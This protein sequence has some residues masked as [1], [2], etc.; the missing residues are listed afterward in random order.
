MKRI[1]LATSWRNEEQPQLVQTLRAWHHKVYDFRNPPSGSGGFAWNQLDP[2]WEKWSTTVY[3][4]KLLTDPVAAQGFM[5]DLRGMQW[6]DTFV[7]LQPCGRSAHL[8]LG[9][10][11]GRGKH[12]IIMLRKGE[13]ELMVLLADELVTNY[14]EL[15]SALGRE[16]YLQE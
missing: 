10:G 8:E 1:Y 5:A 12:T 7:L 14:G 13:P 2:D 11:V 3:R 9:W 16:T 4:E 6:A 15:H